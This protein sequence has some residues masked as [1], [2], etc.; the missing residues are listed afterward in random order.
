LVDSVDLWIRRIN[1]KIFKFELIFMGLIYNNYIN[2]SGLFTTQERDIRIRV[3]EA[4]QRYGIKQV[5]VA[6]ETGI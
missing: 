4:L 2:M 3:N 1:G 5:D 6:R